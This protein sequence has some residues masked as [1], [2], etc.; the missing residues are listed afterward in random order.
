MVPVTMGGCSVDDPDDIGSV[1]VPEDEGVVKP[2]IVVIERRQLIRECLMQSL[3]AAT[4]DQN[5]VSYPSIDDWERSAEHTTGDVV[6]VVYGMREDLRNEISPDS[7]F[8]RFGRNMNLILICD[9]EDSN[10]I[11][12]AINGGVRGYIPT[13]VSLK[14]ALEA[15]RLVRVGGVFIPASALLTQRVD[16]AEAAPNPLRSMFTPRQTAVLE[17]LQKGKANKIIAYELNM[18]ESTVK[19]HVRNIMRKVGATNRTEVAVRGLAL[20]RSAVAKD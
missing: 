15:M 14:V 18:K 12:N 16:G 2:T 4:S 3:R 1:E 17:E 13:S 11:V 8:A 10:E 20:N 5:L 9:S 7:I 19:V 6:V